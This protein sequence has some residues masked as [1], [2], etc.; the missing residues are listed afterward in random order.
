MLKN[1]LIAITGANGFIGRHLSLGLLKSG[2]KLI[3]IVRSV[4]DDIKIDGTQIA[5]DL[6]NASR[7]FE[8]FSNMQPD[9]VIHLA[10]IKNKDSSGNQI[11]DLYDKN[12][13]I[14]LNVIKSS[15]KLPNLKRFIFLGSCDE[16]GCAPC[17]FNEM[18]QEMPANMYGI[19]K[20]AATKLLLG[21][22]TMRQFPAIVLRPSVI[23]GPGQG[24]E[25]FLPALIGSL[26]S[27]KDFDMTHGDQYRDYVYVD[28]VVNAIIKSILAGRQADGSVVNIGFGASWQIKKIATLAAN[29][30]HPNAHNYLKFGALPYRP[31]E[32]MNYMVNIRRAMELLDWQPSKSLDQGLQKTIDSLLS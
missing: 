3:R 17:P 13:E 5:V 20:L 8:I 2:A 28:D 12:S 10:G 23:Y 4:G 11:L 1:S 27:G 31:F 24:N 29:L 18:Q 6:S 15:L 30:I 26:L 16:Y 22:H 7:T 25:M 19:S 32:P 14:T 21:L 9:Y